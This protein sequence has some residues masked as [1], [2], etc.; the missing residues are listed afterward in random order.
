[1]GVGIGL[2]KGVWL[3]HWLLSFIVELMLLEE[4]SCGIYTQYQRI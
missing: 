2:L 4:E 3:R 1:M